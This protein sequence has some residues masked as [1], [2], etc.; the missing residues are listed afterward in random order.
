M[1]VKTECAPWA[2]SMILTVILLLAAGL[3]LWALGFGLPSWFHP[4]DYSFVFFP[5]QFFSGDLNP[6]FFTYPTFHYYLLSLL[7]GLYFCLQ[8]FFGA[9]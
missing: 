8:K 9:G 6:H 1:K 4:D 5:L 2:R 3:R 7:Y